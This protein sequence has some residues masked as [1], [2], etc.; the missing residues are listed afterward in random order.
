M[1]STD[2]R[3]AAD[4]EQ[5]PVRQGLAGG[6]TFA[7]AILLF[8]VSL[9]AVLQGISALAKDDIFIAGPEYTY[10]FDLTT[11]GWIVLILGIIGLAIS[12]GMMTGA[13]WARFAAV[14]IAGLSIVSNFLWLPYYPWWSI[15]VIALDVVVIWAVTTWRTD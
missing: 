8:V 9:L 6:T 7:A 3:T 13:T 10:K 1:T 14:V 5:H 12:V 4:Y 15:L 11:W 2:R